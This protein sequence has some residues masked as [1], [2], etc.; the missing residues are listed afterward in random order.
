MFHMKLRPLSDRV[1]LKK[2]EKELEGNIESKNHNTLH[3]QIHMFIRHPEEKRTQHCRRQTHC[4]YIR[5]VFTLHTF[6]LSIIFALRAVS[7][8]AVSKL[9]I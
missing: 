6:V 4:Q 1:V 9:I 8:N 3:K 2:A 5:S 7:G